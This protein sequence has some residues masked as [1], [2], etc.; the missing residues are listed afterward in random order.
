MSKKKVYMAIDAHAR[1]CVLGCMSARGEFQRTWT[2]KTSEK[3]LIRHVTGVEA[4]KKLLAIE[5][6]SLPYWV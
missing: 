3:E 6:G 5:E 1:N 2:F 4:G